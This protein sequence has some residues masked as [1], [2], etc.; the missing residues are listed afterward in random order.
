[1]CSACENESATRTAISVSDGLAEISLSFLPIFPGSRT[2]KDAKEQ[3]LQAR[4]EGKELK[5]A[6]FDSN[7]ITPGM[8][9]C[10]WS[11]DE[12]IDW[13]ITF[14]LDGLA[15]W[16]DWLID[17]YNFTC[18][19]IPKIS[20]DLTLLISV[21]RFIGTDFMERLDYYLQYMI[22][23]KISSDP[24]WQN[25]D[26]HYSGHLV[27]LCALFC[28]TMF[29]SQM[30]SCGTLFQQVPGEGEH[31]ILDFIRHI[32]SQEKYDPYTRHCLYGLDADL[33]GFFFC[34][35]FSC[36]LPTILF[37]ALSLLNLCY[38]VLQIML[39]LSVHEPFLSLLREEVKFGKNTGAA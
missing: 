31:K 34:C 32:R 8:Y 19:L 5:E 7:V 35:F 4:R 36:F 28:T 29:H 16:I 18:G 10:I 20:L 25:V 6:R 15:Q 21:I 23:N 12:L 24:T 3:E 13:L 37:H 1:M 33:V 9:D 17:W 14:V 27:W 39:G 22:A 11:F 38:F 2:A 30:L 26:V